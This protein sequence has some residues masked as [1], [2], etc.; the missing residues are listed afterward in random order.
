MEG[1][2]L[3][4]SYRTA[5]VT[6]A[7]SGIG[8]EFA[9]QLAADGVSLVVVARRIDRLNE[10]AAE[11]VGRH[12]INVEVLAADLSD[13]KD[14]VRVEERLADSQHP[15]ELLV[16]NA[17]FDNS[18]NFV[19]IPVDVELA[20]LSVNVLTPVRLTRAALPG[21]IARRKGGVLMVSSTVAI[22]PMPRSATYGASKAFLTSFS[23]SVHME[24]EEHGVH[25]TTVAAGLTHTEFHS[26]AGI[27]TSGMPKSAPWMEPGEVAR[28]GLAAVAAGK[29]MVI[30]GL[31]NKW[32]TP[33]FTFLP[34]AMLRA[35]VK[36]FYRAPK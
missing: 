3:T 29:V 19:D 17:G 30:P 8:R 26:V 6:G 14:L 25:V 24:V 34:R 20:E 33:M 10:L 28:V 21:M 5:L 12:G 36:R 23:E 22:M 2:T 31:A 18:G 35:M 13:E 15:I 9:R 27:D 32:Q 7:S 1:T 16:N 11:L 4:Y